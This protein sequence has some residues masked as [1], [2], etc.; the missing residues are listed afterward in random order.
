MLE[1]LL[2]VIEDV[3]NNED[4]IVILGGEGNA[5]CA[6]GDM[7]MLQQLSDKA[8]YDHIMAMIEKVILKLYLMK[9]VVITAVQGSAVGLGLS[10]AL[11]AD[12]V[13]VHKEAKLGVLFIGIGLAPDGGGHF[14]IKERLGTQRAKQFIWSNKQLTSE[15]AKKAGL[16]EIVTEQDVLEEAKQLGSF[17]RQSPMTAILETKMIYHKANEEELLRYLKEEHETQWKLRNTENHQEGVKAFLEKRK[18]VFHGK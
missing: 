12:Y 7:E 2:Q 1:Q 18:P 16:I 15:Q 8:Y 11:T 3:E 14:W 13:L 10:I 9:K 5:F 4:M 6:G 17:F